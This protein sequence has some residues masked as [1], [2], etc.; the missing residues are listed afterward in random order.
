MIAAFSIVV[1]VI[2]TAYWWLQ[3]IRWREK[4]ERERAFRKDFDGGEVLLIEQWPS[5]NGPWNDVL[6]YN[7]NYFSGA[8]A[9]TDPAPN[10]LHEAI[11]RSH[12]NG[13]LQ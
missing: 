7:P 10:R 4:Y 12:M 6:R 1:L 8:K 11:I 13:P 9:M 5:D 3:S 2:A